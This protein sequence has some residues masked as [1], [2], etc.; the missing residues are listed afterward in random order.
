M[1]SVDDGIARRYS[2]NDLVGTITDF[3]LSQSYTN[4]APLVMKNKEYSCAI[5][6]INI[7][8]DVWCEMIL[9]DY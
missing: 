7:P 9:K 8:E 5:P 3:S 1:K 2:Q 4:F 6:T